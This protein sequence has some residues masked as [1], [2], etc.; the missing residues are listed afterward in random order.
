MLK[1][2]EVRALCEGAIMVAL[3][4]ILGYLKFY[5]LPAGGSIT[6]IM[7]P[8]FFYCARWGFLR[9]ILAAFALSLLQFFFDGGFSM[10]WQ[11]MIG[12]YLLAYTALGVAGLF[13][14]RRYGF[15]WGAL[16]GAT[17]RFL[18]AY[19]VGATVW[20]EYMPDRFFNMTMTSPWIYS[21]LYNGFYIFLCMLLCLAVG[22]IMW[23]PIGRYLRG[24]DIN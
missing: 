14:G 15:F 2:K 1:H 3:A 7:L 16:V 22:G 10:T 6:F 24:E 5:S 18:V 17:A 9:G 12:D 21:A 13:R 8:I 20:A 4:Q 19:V 23:K 11:S